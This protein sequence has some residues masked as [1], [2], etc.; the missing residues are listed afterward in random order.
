[1]VRTHFVEI[2]TRKFFFLNWL[3]DP[4]FS[5]PSKPRFVTFGHFVWLKHFS[6]KQRARSYKKIPLREKTGPE[7]SGQGCQIFLGATY[8]N[9]GNYTKL[10]QNTPYGHKM[11]QLAVK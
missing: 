6:K 2:Y 1:M 10:P 4:I 8:Q 9:G 5:V 11:Y 7:C 3:P